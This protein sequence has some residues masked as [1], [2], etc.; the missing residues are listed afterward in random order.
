MVG[1]PQLRY[2]EKVEGIEIKD[3]MVGDEASVARH[4]L[5]VSYPVENGPYPA[6]WASLGP[7]CAVCSWPRPHLCSPLL[8]RPPIFFPL[9]FLFIISSA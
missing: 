8:P 1:R 6:L 4:M 9:L 3:I 5:K 2:E 7:P